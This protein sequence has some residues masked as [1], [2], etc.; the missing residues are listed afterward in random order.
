MGDSTIPVPSLI[1]KMVGH[2]IPFQ[3]DTKIREKGVIHSNENGFI[4]L[5]NPHNCKARVKK[6]NGG[7]LVQENRCVLLA[8][9]AH[10][11]GHY[12]TWCPKDFQYVSEAKAQVAAIKKLCDLKCDTINSWLICELFSWEN[13]PVVACRKAYRSIDKDWI[14][15]L[16]KLYYGI[17]PTL[18]KGV[19]Q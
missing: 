2:H 18:D 1:R 13:N 12:L 6:E 9:V 14:I 8:T 11:C 4:I 19:R 3:Y 10:E 5:V 15:K 16:K 7:Y 17:N